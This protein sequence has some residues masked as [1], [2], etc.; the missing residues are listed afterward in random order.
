M[1]LP[2]ELVVFNIV[3]LF[4]TPHFFLPIFS[5]DVKHLIDG[6]LSSLGTPTESLG[7]T[8]KNAWTK[9][10]H[11]YPQQHGYKPR[12]SW[13]KKENLVPSLWN[14][15]FIYTPT[16]HLMVRT[17]LKKEIDFFGYEYEI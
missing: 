6:P 4:M 11:F 8:N 3:P 17:F 10:K 16:T 14:N 12:P 13:T 5:L 2:N 9:H 1:I 7:H 15:K